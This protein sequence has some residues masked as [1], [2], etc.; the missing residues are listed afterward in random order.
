MKRFTFNI[1][2][3]LWSNI[4]SCDAD[5]VSLKHLWVHTPLPYHHYSIYKEKEEEDKESN[6]EKEVIPRKLKLKID[7]FARHLIITDKINWIDSTGDNI[8]L[9][10][11]LSDEDSNYVKST[12][13]ISRL[14]PFGLD[15]NY[16]NSEYD[17]YYLRQGSDPLLHIAIKK[18]IPLLVSLL[19]EN[20]ADIHY[21]NQQNK[22]ALEV[23]IE[24]GNEEIEVTI[25]NHISKVEQPMKKRKV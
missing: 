22:N 17:P 19:L 1:Q 3:H 20:G 24:T 15:I 2:T 13:L 18:N 4:D 8:P 23:A 10:A 11:L 25:R 21:R 6:K 14:L 12:Y 5:F 16:I 9:G 7:N